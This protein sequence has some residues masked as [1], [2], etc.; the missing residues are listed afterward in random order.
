MS[1][2]SAGSF[3]GKF[4]QK[5]PNDTSLARIAV[6]TDLSDAFLGSGSTDT[7][8]SRALGGKVR[9]QSRYICCE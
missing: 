7:S 1:N 9:E 5:T 6:L 8:A 4:L 3:L 2:L